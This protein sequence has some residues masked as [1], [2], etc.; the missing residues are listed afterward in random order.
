MILNT[1]PDNRKKMVKAISELLG[2]EANYL[3]MPTYSFEIGQVTVNRDG[4]TTCE[5]PATLERIKPMLIENGWLE[6]AIHAE[7]AAEA[8]E[9]AADEAPSEEDTLEET[10]TPENSEADAVPVEEDIHRME[11][12]MPLRSWMD[13][14]LT[15][16]MK[17]FYVRQQ[18][19]NRMLQSDMLFID[20]RF[21]ADLT[22]NP[23][24]GYHDFEVRMKQ[25]IEDRQIRGI[26]FAD[27]KFSLHTPFVRED[28]TR[29]AVHSELLGAILKSA[30]TAD[31]VSL[32]IHYDPENEKYMANSWLVR[33]GFAGP[34]HK[35]LRRTLMKHLTGFAAFK[36]EAEMQ[37]HKDKYAQ[38]RKEYKEAAV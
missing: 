24:N 9:E 30:E 11:L 36:S 1:H 25:A 6:E 15:N 35:E 26:G 23:M 37:A 19:L 20:E 5:D 32:K 27:G 38:L 8:T 2:V 17:I 3:Y 7:P 13:N 31:R 16:L 29:W 12:T 34:R 14:Q 10:V 28:P 4:T 33:M 22:E 21:I 18:L